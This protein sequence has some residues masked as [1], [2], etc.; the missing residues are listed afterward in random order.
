[1]RQQAVSGLKWTTVSQISRISA[2]LLSVLILARL[3]PPADYGLVAMATTVTGFV[4]L[5]RDFGTAAAIIQKDDPS[6]GLLDSIFWLNV[7][8]GVLLAL[9][10][11]LFAPLIAFGFAEPRLKAVLWV[12]LLSFPI[13]SLGAVQQALLEKASR[14]RPLA[15]IETSA[16]FIGLA[17]AVW[18]AWAGW[19]VYSLVLQT[20]LMVFLTTVC[21][22]FASQWRPALR[23]ELNEILGVMRF[24][25]NLVGFNVFNY[26]VR[27]ADNMLIG[28]FLGASELGFY[29]MAYRL[30]LWPLQNISSVV[31]RVLFPA[32]SR[33]QA[34]QGRIA[35]A[36]IR[37]TAAIMLITA[38]LMFG[39]FVLRVP[40][41]AVALGERWQ[42]VADVLVWLVPVG[43]LQSIGTVVG[44][45]YL[46]TG[47]TDVMFKWGIGAGLLVIPAF[48]IGLQWEI[49]GVAAAY[50]VASLL[51]FWPSLAIPFRW[52]GL[53]VGDVLLKLIPSIAT[54]A[55]MAGV[56]EITAIAWDANMTNPWLHLSLL[57]T[58]NELLRLSL[59]VV[60]GIVTYGG[61]SLITQRKLL[62]EL[63]HTVLNR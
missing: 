19:G 59:L 23:W 58:N 61:L 22:W 33:L 24:S 34:D 27:N 21:L 51:L 39:F 46:A 5:F 43:L 9:L 10:L 38:P 2:Q 37:A 41:V 36:Y 63:I 29:T 47:R 62:K 4:S 25:G 54:A 12:L 60:V 40:F 13:T 1:M 20:L 31:G 48:A 6:P 15:I 3:L 28:R 11:G 53:R 17:G 57:N 50:A 26:F 42:P 30:M 18:A 55:V 16:A 49:T 8:F 14:F 56:I 35:G 52:V 32:F 45:L 44:T 7:A